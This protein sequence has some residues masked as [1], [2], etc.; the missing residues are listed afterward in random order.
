MQ[1][2]SENKMGTMPIPKLLLSLS[3]PMA[4]SMLVQALYNVVDSIYVSRV[5]EAA[6]TS[7][8]MAFPMQNLMIAVASG[9]AVG[10]NALLSRSLGAHEFE[11]ANRAAGNGLFLCII[12]T[13]LFVLF[14]LFGAGAFIST[15]TTDELIRGYGTDYLQVVCIV[16][17]FS[18][19]QVMFERLLQSTGRAFFSMITQG[20]GAIINILLDPVFI[21]GYFGLPAMGVK[22]A[23]IATVIGQCVA[24]LLALYFNLTRNADI[25]LSLKRLKPEGATISEILRVG[26][27]T[28]VM[29]SIGSVMTFAMNKIL[30][31]FSSTAVAVFGVYFRMQSF[32]VM[33]VIG[34][35]GGLVP[36]IAY[37]YG[38][39]RPKR[40]MQ[41]LKLGV[42]SAA[43][44]MI[45]GLL[46]F[47]LVPQQLLSLFD[48]SE[49]MT[50]MGVSAL[51]IIS[52][53]FPIAAFCIVAGSM[54]QALS[55]S[56]YSMYIS[57]MRQLAVL[58]PVAW[59]L[60]LT[61]NVNMVWLSFPIA[62]LMSLVCSSLFLRHVYKKRVQPLYEQPAPGEPNGSKID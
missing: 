48:A 49:E 27:P 23:A 43:V 50:A 47:Q 41:A 13:L 21:F 3:L 31:G 35:N 32:V 22:G 20:T 33:P 36:I 9:F 17:V 40:I 37:N 60:S 59:L 15:Q 25:Q 30:I 54:F 26:I 34:I 56:I 2:K 16:S 24:M 29:Q 18:F 45:C 42:A 8:S 12:G 55:E 58:I 62:E 19:G 52:I 11:K 14:G 53:H 61:G 51:R 1:A 44:I 28:T 5:N 4:L 38:A 39:R 57:I 46:L 6:L 10:V 7:L